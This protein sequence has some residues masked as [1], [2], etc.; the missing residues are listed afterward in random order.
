M[1]SD[2]TRGRQVPGQITTIAWI[3]IVFGVGLV[4]ACFANV[5]IGGKLRLS[6]FD[7]W[8]PGFNRCGRWCNS[9]QALGAMVLLC[10][11]DA[12]SFWCSSGH[13]SWWAYDL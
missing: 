10:F 13:N 3:Y 5:E 7:L 1:A 9:P 4:A 11:I 8:I 6:V 12:H 2:Q